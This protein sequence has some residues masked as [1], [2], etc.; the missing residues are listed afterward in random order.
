VS[1]AGDLLPLFGLFMLFIVGFAAITRSKHQIV[2]F[3]G[4]IVVALVAASVAGYF[5]LVNVAFDKLLLYS[6]VVLLLLIILSF[7]L[8][9]V[10]LGML[11]AAIRR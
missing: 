3:T 11:R 8:L 4:L 7:V 6:V 2:Q 9:S 10:G 5:D 1:L